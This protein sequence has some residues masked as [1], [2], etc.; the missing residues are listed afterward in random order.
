MSEKMKAGVLFGGFFSLF[1][2]AVFLFSTGLSYSANIDEI[3]RAIQ[4]RGLNWVAGE[5]P[6]SNLTIEEMRKL[7]GALEEP[8]SGMAANPSFYVP[9]PLAAK[10]DWTDN[11]GN[12]VTGVRSQGGCGSCWAFATTAALESK[13]LITFNTPNQNLDLSEQIVL[14]CTDSLKPSSDPGTNTCDGGYASSAADV[15]KNYGTAVESCYPYTEANGS[16]G[17]ACT[18]WQNDTYMIKDWSYVINNSS[19]ITSA[20]AIKTALASGPV[21]AWMRV[22]QDL[23][24]YVSGVYARTSTS[25]VGNHF[26]LIV[27]YDDAKGGG[28]AFKIKNSWGTSFGQSGFGW[29]AYSELY[30]GGEPTNHT[31]FGRWVYAFGDAV[32]NSPVVQCDYIIDFYPVSYS[33]KVIDDGYYSTSIGDSGWEVVIC[34]NYFGDTS[35]WFS[36]DIYDNGGY[37]TTIY[38]TIIW[39]KAIGATSAYI[40]G[41]AVESDSDLYTFYMDGTMKYSRGKYTFSSKAGETY[42]NGGAPWVVLLSSFKSSAG[43]VMDK[44]AKKDRGPRVGKKGKSIWKKV[45]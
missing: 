4:E 7:T 12:Y 23:Y 37:R 14:S 26:V 2:V 33:G 9:V 45:E 6:L 27:G 44:D 17:N 16:C 35:D 22:Y 25:F 10:L 20:S 31:Q 8:D 29:I 36:G 24:S 3:N 40:Q 41:T 38:G 32:R 21:I 1:V 39:N 43:Y 11:G 30:P 15:L 13:A 5:T 28:G 42:T 34:G 18:N 19:A